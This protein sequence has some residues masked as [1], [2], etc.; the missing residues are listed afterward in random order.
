[1]FILAISCLTTSIL[2]RFIDL[3]FQVPMQ[4]F[5]LQHRTFLSLPHTSAAERPSGFGP[6]TS[7]ALELLV[8]VLHSSSVACWMPSYLRGSSSSIISF[9]FLF[10]W[11][12]LGKDTGVACQFLLQVDHVYSELSTVTCPSLVSLHAIAHSFSELLK[13]LCHDKAAVHEVDMH[14][15]LIHI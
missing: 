8:L 15:S 1:M 11:S 9:S 7:L 12:F 6:T 14:L 4:Y 3:T 10:L 5:S 13:P 2:P